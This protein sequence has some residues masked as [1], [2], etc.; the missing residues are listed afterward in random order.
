MLQVHNSKVQGILT[1][2]RENFE[3][4]KAQKDGDAVVDDTT[5]SVI[6]EE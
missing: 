2:F 4:R 1:N 6:L 3:K 5:A